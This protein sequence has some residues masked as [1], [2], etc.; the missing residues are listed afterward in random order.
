MDLGIVSDELARTRLTQLL[1]RYI[2][3]CT[4]ELFLAYRPDVLPYPPTTEHH[5][6]LHLGR[7][8]RFCG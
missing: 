1:D 6:N 8:H 5:S 7:H 4:P 2:G 3:R